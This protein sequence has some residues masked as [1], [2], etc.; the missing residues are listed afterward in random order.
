MRSLT[1]GYSEAMLSEYIIA[2]FEV[3]LFHTLDISS[4]SEKN[5]G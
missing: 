2:K 3:L 4:H 1:E 5:G